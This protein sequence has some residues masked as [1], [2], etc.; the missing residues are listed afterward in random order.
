LKK[1]RYDQFFLQKL[2]VIW[3]QKTPIFRELNEAKRNIGP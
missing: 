1:Q 2:A 3:N